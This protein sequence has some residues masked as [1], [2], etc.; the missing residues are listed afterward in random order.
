MEK[1][2]SCSYF[3]C[4]KCI[5][6]WIDQQATLESESY[7]L[8]PA[9]AMVEVAHVEKNKRYEKKALESTL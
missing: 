2:S 7:I 9:K 5:D 3:F 1:Q 6:R 4:G 8:P